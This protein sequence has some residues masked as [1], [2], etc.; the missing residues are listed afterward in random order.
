MRIM[1]GERRI[2][3]ATHNGLGQT[4]AVTGRFDFLFRDMELSARSRHTA[5]A[6]VLKSNALTSWLLSVLMSVMAIG[7]VLLTWRASRR[8][9]RLSRMRNGFVTNVSHELRTPLA[10]MAVFGELLRRGHVTA[11]DKVVDYGCRIEQESTRLRHLIDNVLSF[12]RIESTHVRYRPQTVAMEEVV[13]AAVM[14]VDN[15]RAQGGFTI[16]VAGTDTRLPRIRVDSMAMTQVFVNLLDNAMKYSGRCRRIRV[17]LRRCGDEVTV[18]IADS[19]IGIAPSEQGRIFDE[20]YRIA[21]GESVVS[22]TGLGLAIAR[23]VVEAH[24]GRIAVNSRVGYGAVFTVLLPVAPATHR[25]HF[26]VS[27][28]LRRRRIEVEA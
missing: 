25:Q 16:S 2:V 11:P 18:S 14:A 6:Q 27:S 7:G 13:G 24:G 23:R 20:F 19:G 9:R 1:D 26:E 15:R 21:G 10:S 17:E 3:A 8:E 5:A 28:G 22:G 4:D 12:S